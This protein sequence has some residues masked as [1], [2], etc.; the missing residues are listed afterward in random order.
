MHKLEKYGDS[1]VK[2]DCL[3]CEGVHGNS[4]VCCAYNVACCTAGTITN[5]RALFSN[6]KGHRCVAS[7]SV[8]LKQQLPQQVLHVCLA[9]NWTG[10]SCVQGIA[11]TNIM[12][13]CC[14]TCTLCCIV[15]CISRSAFSCKLTSTMP[16]FFALHL[17][18]QA[19]QLGQPGPFETPTSR[20]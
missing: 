3:A 18:F 13:V 15:L 12:S 16:R 5:R 14:V 4:Q 17:G 11:H 10:I 20:R 7:A 2:W 8:I 6:V 9:I 1:K 19:W